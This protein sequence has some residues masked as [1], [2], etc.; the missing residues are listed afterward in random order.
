MNGGTTRQSVLFSDLLAQPVM[1]KFDQQQASSEGGAVLLQARDRKPGLTE[2]L[3][4]CVEDRHQSGKIRHVIGEL[5]RQRLYAI[6]C[7]YTDGNDAQCLAADPIQKM[8]CGQDPVGGQDL[9]S[10]PTL[11]CFENAVE[12]SDLYRMPVTAADLLYDRVL[13]FYEALGVGVGP[14]VLPHVSLLP[15]ASP[16]M[17]PPCWDHAVLHSLVVSKPK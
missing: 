15:V 4:G 16:T 2:A 13:P 11:S 5:V 3:V 17:L 9:S 14:V 12:R 6:V 8:L 10:Q 7:G 1:V